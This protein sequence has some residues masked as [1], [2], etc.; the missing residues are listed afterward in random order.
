MDLMFRVLNIVGI[1]GFVS[2]LIAIY[3]ALRTLGSAQSTGR[4]KFT[5]TVIAI[6]CIG[7]VWILIAGKLLF[8][9]LNY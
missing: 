8:F 9:N 3:S 1:I 5:E 2:A 6:G 4:L 7:F